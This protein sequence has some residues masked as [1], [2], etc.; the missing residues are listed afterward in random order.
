MKKSAFNDSRQTL[1][2]DYF[3]CTHK[4]H[5]REFEA[6]D[7]DT[8]EINTV[9]ISCKYISANQ[10]ESDTLKLIKDELNAL[11]IRVDKIE[12]EREKELIEMN[13]PF[14]EEKQV[15][16]ELHFEDVKLDDPD[17][18]QAAF[19]TTLK[20]KIAIQAFFDGDATKYPTNE[21]DENK[22]LSRITIPSL[23]PTGS[24]TVK[25][26][27]KYPKEA[28]DEQGSLKTFLEDTTALNDSFSEF[29]VVESTKVETGQEVKSLITK[30]SDLEDRLNADELSFTT[31]QSLRLSDF[32]IQI[33]E[34]NQFIKLLHFDQELQT[35]VGAQ[36]LLET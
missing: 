12:S 4:A 34:T 1:Q 27:I 28:E 15:T 36:I 13:A 11:R 23:K 17:F 3:T 33:D 10:I 22:L 9:N 20:K 30:I 5:F 18:D 7:I 19:V 24:A 25:V 8:K 14:S 32:K 35:Y 6:T 2:C 21:E 31:A 16:T 26:E 29:G